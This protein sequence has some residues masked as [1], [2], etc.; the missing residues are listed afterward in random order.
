VVQCGIVLVRVIQLGIVR[1]GTRRETDARGVYWV[2]GIKRSSCE[3]LRE[4]YINW[5]M[6]CLGR[7]WQLVGCSH[8]ELNREVWDGCGWNLAGKD[9]MMHRV[10]GGCC[11]NN[12]LV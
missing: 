10:F 9:V 7:C 1:G 2:L 12:S 8:L 4:E 11:K 5:C 6:G 3:T